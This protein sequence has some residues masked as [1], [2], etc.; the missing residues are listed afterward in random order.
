MERKQLAHTWSKRRKYRAECKSLARNG[1][2]ED[3]NESIKLTI[4]QTD[5]LWFCL[6]A[7]VSS[8]KLTMTI[9]AEG[10]YG[11][12]SGQKDRVEV[13]TAHR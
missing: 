13:A 11:A 5:Q 6:A 8:P 4:V 10:E 12:I 3:Q 7:H 1:N 9:G 2:D